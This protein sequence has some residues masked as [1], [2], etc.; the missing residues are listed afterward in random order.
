M[1][2]TGSLHQF[3]CPRQAD[4]HDAGERDERRS[5]G[6]AAPNKLATRQFACLPSSQIRMAS[7]PTL[8]GKV[9]LKKAPIMLKA[10]QAREDRTGRRISL[11]FVASVSPAAPSAQ[12]APA[13]PRA[14]QP[15]LIWL[16]RVATVPRLTRFSAKYSSRPEM[17]ALARA[18][19]I[20][21][22]G[23]VAAASSR[24]DQPVAASPTGSQG[25]AEVICGRSDFPQR[26]FR[27]LRPF[28]WRRFLPLL[29]RS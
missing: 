25:G 14:I 11:R 21:R 16:R 13:R 5:R 18:E 8:E 6:R 1:R 10:E 19:N 20:L 28:G 26:F 15:G 7:P 9:W 17:A 24:E 4:D 27:S 2:P 3:E 12:T 23:G 29:P 22:I